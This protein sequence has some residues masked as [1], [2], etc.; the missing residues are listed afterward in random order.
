MTVSIAQVKQASIDAM[1]AGDVEK[2]KQ[3]KT[4]YMKY[5]GDRLNKINSPTGGMFNALK[6]GIDQPLE[7]M[8]T[9][10][11]ALGNT[12]LADTLSNAV[13]SVEGESAS[14]QFMNQ[15]GEGYDFRY[16][17]KAVL[18]QTGQFAGSIA[19]RGAGAALGGTLGSVVPGVGTA[20]GAVVGGITAPIVFEATQ[21]LGSIALERAKNNGREVPTKEDWTWATGSATGAGILNTLAPNMRGTLKRMLVEGGTEAAQSITTQAGASAQ[22]DA[23]LNLDVKQAVGEGIIGA[24]SAGAVDTA[25]YPV[26]S[27]ANRDP[28]PVVD[29]EAQ[30][31]FANRLQSIVKAGDENGNK[32]NLKDTDPNSNNGAVAVI[33]S[34]HK[35]IANQIS[36]SAD[37]LKD[38]LSIDNTFLVDD[39]A[40][41]AKKVRAKAAISMAKNKVKS[42]VTS[43]DMSIIA[44]LVGDTPEGQTLINLI[45][46]SMELT[47]LHK[48]GYIGGLSQYTDKINPFAASGIYS[49]G[50]SAGRQFLT[51]GSLIGAYSTL[52]AST[53]IQAGA[54]GGAK[55]IDAITG[56]KSKVRSYLDKN[57]GGKG[58]AKPYGLTKREKALKKQS[59]IEDANRVKRN[60]E[61]KEKAL[62]QEQIYRNYI[63]NLDPNPESP[64]GKYQALTGLDTAG[65]KEMIKVIHN[66]PDSLPQDRAE[67][68]SL[69]KSMRQGGRITG[70]GAH[71]LMNRIMDNDPEGYGKL[72]VTVPLDRQS[73]QAILQEHANENS[74]NYQRGIQDNQQFLESLS[75]ALEADESISKISKASLKLAHID[76]KNNLGVDP[77]NSLQAIENRLIDQGV[78]QFDLDKYFVPYRDRVVQQQTATSPNQ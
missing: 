5:Q 59:E 60:I 20:T 63:Q 41:R 36:D 26:T 40:T 65:M 4:L 61:A 46:E 28:K 43:D 52:G 2:A 27:L 16:L 32:F 72:R 21:Q 7:G 70:F 64:Q 17:P 12:G 13:D 62:Q 14:A 31:A 54:I 15:G 53:A 51:A 44:E 33:D 37:I 73:A 50:A 75:E 77:I 47:R 56:K 38:E 1:K 42:V 58:F 6:R 55:V 48:Q 18:E 45:R 19:S 3:L 11:R 22:T 9:T 29:P 78:S 74:P 66:D 25:I 68:K 10:A 35:T 76:M 49:S 24:G 30:Q 69:L 67:M 23:G 39:D 71:Q 57:T 8:A 34:A